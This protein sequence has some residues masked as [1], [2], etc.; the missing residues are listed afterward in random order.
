MSATAKSTTSCLTPIV[1]CLNAAEEV[2]GPDRSWS[3]INTEQAE[4]L[5]QYLTDKIALRRLPELESIASYDADEINRF[6]S[7]RGFSISL[8]KFEN[9]D[10]GVASVF[11]L[12]VEWLE[13][14]DQAK[15][16]YDGTLYPGVRLK[17]NFTVLTPV[18]TAYPIARLATKS[19][20]E[21]YLKA[22]PDAPEDF[23]DH[24]RQIELCLLGQPD[25][26]YKS[27]TFPMVEVDQEV[28]ITWIRGLRTCGDDGC[29]AVVAQALQQTKFRMNEVGAKVES[30]A[31]MHMLRMVA[32]HDPSEKHL[33]IDQPFLLW[34]RRQGF[35]R[36]LFI[37]WFAPDN[38]KQSAQL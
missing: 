22:H 32:I 13:K 15:V 35:E 16:Y 11:K 7:E 19:G 3:G 6:L 1:G 28:D 34:I 5:R 4:F 37:G 29:P 17:S 33:V 21:V 18:N 38:W 36:P 2:L 12:L 25:H 23:L 14:G 8:P 26:A 24:T 20:D 30:A 9:P 27:V 31:A 10:F